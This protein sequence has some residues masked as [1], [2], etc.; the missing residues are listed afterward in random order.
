MCKEAVMAYL[1]HNY[2]KNP[3]KLRKSL[4]RTDGPKPITNPGTPE[5]IALLAALYKVTMFLFMFY[6]FVTLSVIE[7]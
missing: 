1:R 7:C 5:Y 2:M 6:F 4:V 3:R